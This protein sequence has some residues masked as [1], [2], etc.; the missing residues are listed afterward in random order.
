MLG[1]SSKDFGK[2][3]SLGGFPE[4]KL[5]FWVKQDHFRGFSLHFSQVVP[6]T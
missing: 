1:K 6:I 5:A 3:S 4:P 2:A